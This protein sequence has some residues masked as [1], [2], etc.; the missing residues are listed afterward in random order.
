MI[1][2]FMAAASQVDG[3]AQPLQ[4]PVT[5]CKIAGDFDILLCLLELFVLYMCQ[6]HV[7]QG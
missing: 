5:G 2:D 6:R 1:G 3:P 7:M 4:L